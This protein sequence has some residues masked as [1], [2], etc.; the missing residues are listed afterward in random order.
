MVKVVSLYTILWVHGTNPPMSA[1]VTATNLPFY[2]DSS[3]SGA[4]R[5]KHDFAVNDKGAA[6][7]RMFRPWLLIAW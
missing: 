1:S 2:C 6:L 5:A 3:G 4:S 7:D